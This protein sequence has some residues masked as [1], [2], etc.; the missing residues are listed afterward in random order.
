MARKTLSTELVDFS[1][2]LDPFVDVTLLVEGMLIEVSL[3][4]GLQCFQECSLQTSER[5]PLSKFPHQE[6]KRMT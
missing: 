2:P 3:G 4:C 5:K 6:R 1:K